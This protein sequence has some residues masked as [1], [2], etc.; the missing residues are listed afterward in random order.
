MGVL[1]KAR[2]Q[3]KRTRRKVKKEAKRFTKSD[4]GKVIIGAALLLKGPALAKGLLKTGKKLAPKV[5][6]AIRGT[7][8]IP[9]VGGAAATKVPGKAI[10]LGSVGG[11]VGK[12]ALGLLKSEGVQ[13]GIGQGVAGAITGRAGQEAAR[14][15]GEEARRDYVPIQFSPMAPP[16][17]VQTPTMDEM[18]IYQGGQ[19]I[20][21]R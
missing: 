5:A 1:R 11:A 15:A 13:R 18:P 2:K 3:L 16:P 10:T 20:P 19:I 17:L 21:R 14:A 8:V 9:G 7:K 12:G 6:K 4:L